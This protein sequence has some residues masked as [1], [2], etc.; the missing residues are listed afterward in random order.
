MYYCNNCGH[1]VYLN[2]AENSS[3]PGKKASIEMECLLCKSHTTYRKLVPE[4]LN[5]INSNEYNLTI[6]A[7]YNEIMKIKDKNFEED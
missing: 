6:K 2:R 4:D 7:L 1:I 5:S 3:K